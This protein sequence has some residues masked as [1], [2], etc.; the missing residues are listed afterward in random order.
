MDICGT[1]VKP[2]KII[3]SAK[4]SSAVRILACS[5]QLYLSQKTISLFH[6]KLPRFIV[7]IKLF[8]DKKR[9][10][11]TIKFTQLKRLMDGA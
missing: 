1:K 9:Q 8:I 5:R 10:S 2:T 4:L 3:I 11:R 7:N 6:S